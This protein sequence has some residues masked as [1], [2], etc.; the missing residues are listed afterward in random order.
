MIKNGSNLFITKSIT[1]KNSLCNKL[2]YV[3]CL[4]NHL[5]IN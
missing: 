2:K 5:T 1:N 3:T 4:Q